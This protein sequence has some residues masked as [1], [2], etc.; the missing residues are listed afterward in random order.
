MI[1]KLTQDKGILARLLEKGI[2]IIIKKECKNIGEV[3]I[4]IISSSIQIIKGLI[5]RIH[6][7]GKDVNYKDLLFDKIELEANEVKINFKIDYKK[8]KFENN[9]IVEFKISLSE[10]SLKTI[11]LNDSWN[12]IGNMIAKEIFNKEM[13]DDIKIK[14]D[15]IIIYF[16]N[17]NKVFNQIET[18]DIKV[19]NENIF[20]ESQTY[21][22]CIKIPIEDKVIIKNIKIQNNKI[23]ICAKSPLSF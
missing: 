12:W 14:N 15:Q 20:F 4:E 5:Q 1:L 19:L 7:S 13:L 17:E 3:D 11:L 10:S 23:I 18:L 9:F 6:I 21:N 2:K 22:K 16:F 8:L